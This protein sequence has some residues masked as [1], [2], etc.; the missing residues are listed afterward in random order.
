MLRERREGVTFNPLGRSWG[1]AAIGGPIIR[2][3]SAEPSS[4]E[5]ILIELSAESASTLASCSLVQFRAFTRGLCA[6]TPSPALVDGDTAEAVLG[7]N[8]A[9]NALQQPNRTWMSSGFY[10]P[11]LRAV[12]SAKSLGRLSSARSEG[13]RPQ[14]AV[15]HGETRGRI[16][17]LI[18]VS[19]CKTNGADHVRVA[20]DLGGSQAHAFSNLGVIAEFVEDLAETGLLDA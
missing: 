10:R 15:L 7:A 5:T 4:P 11:V 8:P 20:I 6:F 17:E 13:V 1:G 3:L 16:S 2:I 12:E 9:G 18:V 19:L 14:S